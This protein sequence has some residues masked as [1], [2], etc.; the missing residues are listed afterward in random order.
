VGAL[1]DADKLAKG[2]SDTNREVALTVQDVRPGIR[3][4]S[5]HTLVDVDALIAEVR[6]FVS[7][8]SRLASQLE[9]DPTRLLFGDRREGYQPK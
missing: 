5:Q 1:V 6:Q 8:L 9:R 7:G 4:F 2:L 3:N